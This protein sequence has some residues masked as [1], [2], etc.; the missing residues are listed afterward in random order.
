[1][2]ANVCGDFIRSNPQE[3]LESGHRCFPAVEEKDEFV[4]VGLQILRIDSMMST[5]EPRFKIA[6][7]PVDVRS[8]HSWILPVPFWNTLSTR[9]SESSRPPRHFASESAFAAVAKRMRPAFS[10]L[11]LCLCQYTQS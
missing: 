8:P 11:S 1:M 6:K 3:R 9:R 10:A 7:S 4:K 5:I 2:S